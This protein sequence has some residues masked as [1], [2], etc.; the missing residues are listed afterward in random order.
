MKCLR[1]GYCCKNYMVV[2]VDDPDEDFDP[3]TFESVE[4]NTTVHM[5]DGTPC[6]HLRGENPG[7]YMCALHDKPWYSSTPC[8]AH[9]QIERS[10]DCECRMGRYVLDNKNDFS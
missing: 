5:G 7:E 4:N 2:I 8:Y 6:K 3:E 1:C 9:G 10:V